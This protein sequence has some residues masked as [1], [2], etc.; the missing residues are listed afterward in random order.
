LDKNWQ[1]ALHSD[2]V[3]FGKLVVVLIV[4][5]QS[6]NIQ[7]LKPTIPKMDIT[8]AHLLLKYRL[9]EIIRS[10]KMLRNYTGFY[11]F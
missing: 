1:I 10:R 3:A 5:S 6:C 8:L 9:F 2:Y 11:H 7:P 4:T